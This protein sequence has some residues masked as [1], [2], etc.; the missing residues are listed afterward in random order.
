[1][2][3]LTPALLV[4]AANAFVG[5][6]EEG[7]DNRGQMVEL[8]LSEVAQPPGQPWCAAF[9]SHVG[10]WSHYDQEADKSSWPLPPTA[11]CEELGNFAKKCKLE[12]KEPQ[13]GDI[14]LKHSAELNRFAH[15]GIVVSVDKTYGR[16]DWAEFVCTTIEGNTNDDGSANGHT[17]LRKTRTLRVA[18]GDRFVRWVDMELRRAAA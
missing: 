16:G 5:L 7:G 4:A 11:S 2:I 13:I 18:N 3:P 12:S 9:V 6:G 8:F 10:K 17:T 14:F 1:M 15:T